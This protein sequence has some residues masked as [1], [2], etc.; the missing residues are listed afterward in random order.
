MIAATPRN[1]SSATKFRP[2]NG[3]DTVCA[4][5]S[6]KFTVP[7]P[8]ADVDGRHATSNCLRNGKDTE[9]AASTLAG[10]GYRYD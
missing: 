8:I 1:P 4:A 7:Q 10:R 2:V 9:A 6:G 5:G 3:A